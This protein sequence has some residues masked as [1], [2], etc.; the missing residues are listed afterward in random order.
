MSSKPLIAALSVGAVAAAGVV[1][2]VLVQRGDNSSTP[3][4][5]GDQLC[6]EPGRDIPERDAPD[7]P[8][9]R[10][11][12]VGD[13]LD[14]DASGVVNAPVTSVAPSP[15]GPRGLTAFDSGSRK[16]K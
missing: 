7:E 11:A 9:R 4:G 3:A 16:A 8:A 2:L 14:V 12:H 5:R 6:A 15:T 1:F 13:R 10:R